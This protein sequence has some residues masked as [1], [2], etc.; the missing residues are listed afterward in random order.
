MA[1]TSTSSTTEQ[2]TDANAPN[3]DNPTGA[4]GQDPKA[5]NGEQ[6]K[7]EPKAFTQ[8]ELDFIVKERLERER[9]KAEKIAAD[10]KAKAEEETLAKQQEW[11]KLALKREADNATL[12]GQLDE[13]QPTLEQTKARIAALEKALSSQ[14]AALTEGLDEGIVTLL[15]NRP[16]EEQLVWLSEYRANLPA[17]NGARG[18]PATPK[19]EPEAASEETKAASRKGL[20]RNVRNWM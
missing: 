13:L 19:A 1:D 9:K 14:V 4:E 15:K 12:R 18:I 2:P 6:P 8:A 7:E 11:E 10:A 20:A 17:K 3:T 5:E 16:V